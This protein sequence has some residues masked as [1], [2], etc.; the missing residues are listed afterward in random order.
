ELRIVV[1]G[2]TAEGVDANAVIEHG[3]PAVVAIMLAVI[4]LVLLVTFRSVLLAA[5]AIALNLLSL[6]ATYGILVLVFQRGLG[7]RLLGQQQVA[8]RILYRSCCSPSCSV[9][10]LTTRCSCSTESAR[11]TTPEPTTRR[12]WRMVSPVPRP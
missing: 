6:G 4:Y 8:S 1:G 10:A 5:K 3:L 12:A 2:E 11:S 7:A 9:S